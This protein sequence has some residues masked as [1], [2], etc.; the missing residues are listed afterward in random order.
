[1]AAMRNSP[2][3]V[4]PLAV[5]LFVSCTR[6]EVDRPNQRQR[7]QSPSGRY[8]VNV[9]IERDAQDN[10]RYWRVTI[11]DEKGVVV[12]KDDSKFVGNLNVYWYWDQ[13]DRLWLA[14]SDNGNIYY[15]ETDKNGNWQ[16]S[17]WSKDKK[18]SLIPP[19]E[20]FPESWVSSK[21]LETL[22]GVDQRNRASADTVARE[23]ELCPPWSELRQEDNA[24]RQQILICLEKIANYDLEVI[25]LG[26][27]KYVSTRRSQ[28]AFDVSAMSR[29]YVLNRYVFNV[30][31]KASL[32]RPTF[33]GWMGVPHDSQSINLLWPLTV[34]ENG[35]LTLTGKFGGYSGDDYLA[36]QEFNYFK[37]KYSVR[38][39]A[40]KEQ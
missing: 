8:V 32:D 3:T 22:V 14:N 18:Q 34:D 12:F 26:M 4:L 33:G 19:H 29:L 36:L 24:T 23:I 6:G 27:E 16:R 21:S 1:M 17:Q 30:P 37:E 38:K 40:N 35:K 20:L 13:N 28:K 10:H 31:A 39:N 7:F 5:I 11:L 25:Q 2:Q 9:P 15:W